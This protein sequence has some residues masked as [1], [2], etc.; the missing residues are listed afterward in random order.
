MVAGTTSVPNRSIS[1]LVAAALSRPSSFA[2]AIRFVMD[3][4]LRQ[5]LNS[6]QSKSQRS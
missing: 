5:Q 6:A 4:Q 1:F 3:F 2:T